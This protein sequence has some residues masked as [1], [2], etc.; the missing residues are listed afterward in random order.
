MITAVLNG[1]QL[2]PLELDFIN[3][4]I[5]NAQDVQTLDGSIYTDF[6]SLNSAWTLNYVSLTEDQYNAIRAIYNS[7]FTLFEYPLLTISYYGVEDVPVR[8]YINEKDIWN[9]CGS[10]RNVQLSFRETNQ[11]S[12]SS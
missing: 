12:E 4:P 8:M 11:L 6:S 5:E 7:Q 3:T 10:V 9:H 2:P 1:L